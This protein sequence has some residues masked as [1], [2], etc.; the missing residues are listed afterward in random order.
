MNRCDNHHTLYLPDLCKIVNQKNEIWNEII[1]HIHPKMSCPLKPPTYRFVN[2]TIDMSFIS[3][4]PLDGFIWTITFKTFKPIPNV[5][6]K[7]RM[8][9][10]WMVEGSI[11]R[12][13]RKP[14]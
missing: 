11:V 7:K 5:R 2:A 4:L 8:V 6:H 3:Y 14:K 9:H 1:S 12:V 10:C 13:K